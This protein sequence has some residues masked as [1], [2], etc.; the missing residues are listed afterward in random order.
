MTT[1]PPSQAKLFP[2]SIRPG[3]YTVEA[4]DTVKVDGETLPRRHPSAKYGL[5]SKLGS[6]ITT[7]YD[8][9]I[10]GAAKFDHSPA[11]G[12]RRVNNRHTEVKRTKDHLGQPVDKTWCYFELSEYEYVSYQQL[13]RNALTAGS[14]LVKLGLRKHDRVEIYA[15]TSPFWFTVAQGCAKFS[16]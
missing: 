10:R 7:V 5:R 13:K 9:L 4:D 14:A 1:T 8:I 16:C 11:I 12:F 2:R 6:G 15:A 3:P